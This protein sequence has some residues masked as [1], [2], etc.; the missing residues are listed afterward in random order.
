[1]VKIVCGGGASRAIQIGGARKLPAPA[2]MSGQKSANRRFTD[3]KWR[4]SFRV[5]H[6]LPCVGSGHIL[7]EPKSR[8]SGFV[9]TPDE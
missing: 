7:H 6:R 8:A 5:P 4:S 9:D 1:M 3:G 2:V